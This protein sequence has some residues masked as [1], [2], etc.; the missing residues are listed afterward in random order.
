MEINSNVLSK[1]GVCIKSVYLFVMT[2]NCIQVQYIAAN[3][4]AVSKHVLIYF[5]IKYTSIY[6]K[7]FFSK[8]MI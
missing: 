1:K 8:C 4:L 3:L 2:R 7:Q 6:V 5:L